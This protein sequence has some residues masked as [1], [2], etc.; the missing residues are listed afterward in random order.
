MRAQNLWASTMNTFS[1]RSAALFVHYSHTYFIGPNF[2]FVAV[3]SSNEVKQ[4]CF[5]SSKSN[6]NFIE[7]A[8]AGEWENKWAKEKEM[9][10]DLPSKQSHL[11]RRNAKW[12]KIAACLLKQCSEKS[13]IDKVRSATIPSISTKPRF[14]S[15]SLCVESFSDSFHLCDWR[16]NHFGVDFVHNNNDFRI[17]LLRQKRLQ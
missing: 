9:K 15:L 8:R 6:I 12:F 10:S 7:N 2:S 3:L 16:V 11:F 13:W 14:A 5:C 4:F 1:F 17:P